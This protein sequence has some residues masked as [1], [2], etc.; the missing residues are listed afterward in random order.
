MEGGGLVGSHEV[1]GK[2]VNT[3]KSQ[4]VSIGAIF[5]SIFHKKH[6]NPWPNTSATHVVNYSQLSACP[7]EMGPFK[8]YPNICGHL[9]SI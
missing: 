2:A 8:D 4:M 9:T 3:E 5:S 7:G 6:L 1:V